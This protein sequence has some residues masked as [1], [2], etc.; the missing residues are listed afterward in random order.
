MQKNFQVFNF[1]FSFVC[2]C[3]MCVCLTGKLRMYNGHGD[4]DDRW[5]IRVSYYFIT[6]VPTLFFYF[7]K[8]REAEGG[9]QCLQIS[10]KSSGNLGEL[11]S[12]TENFYVLIVFNNSAIF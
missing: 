10:K 9:G 1:L 6:Y 11:L 12:K 3:G 5:I 4:D 2:V 8:T 7:I